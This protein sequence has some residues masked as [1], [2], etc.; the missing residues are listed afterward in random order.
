[1][2]IEKHKHWTFIV[3]D[4]IDENGNYKHPIEVT[5]NDEEFE[6]NALNEVRR[7]I[8]RKH[9]TL[10]KVWECVTCA[11]AMNQATNSRNLVEELKKHK[12]E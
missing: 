1:M 3:Y 10:R 6:S 12:H 11:A 5:V 9:Y 2:S 8:K 7:M 4:E